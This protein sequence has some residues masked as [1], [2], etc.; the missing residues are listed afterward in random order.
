M[1]DT[2]NTPVKH[3]GVSVKRRRFRFCVVCARNLV[4]FR[5]YCILSKDGIGDKL[6]T[7]VQRTHDDIKLVSNYICYNC[8]LKVEQVCS[9]K[10]L[11]EGIKTTFTELEAS[12]TTFTHERVKRMANSPGKPRKR[13]TVRSSVMKEYET[14]QVGSANLY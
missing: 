2:E 9:L 11:E 3:V 6:T 12:T 14:S 7:I 8:K 4:E 10:E 1:A 13:N 5:K